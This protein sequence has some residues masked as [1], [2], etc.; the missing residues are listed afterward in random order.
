[1]VETKK[2]D[3]HPLVY[4]FITLTLILPIATTTVERIFF[5]MNIVK[6]G[7]RNLT[8]EEWMSDSLVIYIEKEFSN[9]VTNEDIMQRFQKM[10]TRHHQF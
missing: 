2:N 7:L 5:A 3:V 9:R 1:M 10:K 4:R 6:N 8:G